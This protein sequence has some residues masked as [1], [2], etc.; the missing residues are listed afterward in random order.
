MRLQ[1]FA[2]IARYRNSGDPFFLLFAPQAVHTGNDYSVLQ[3]PQSFVDRFPGIRDH[4][5]RVFAGMLSALDDSV[6]EIFEELS[7][8]EAINNTIIVFTTDNGGATGGTEFR[9][10][11][12]VG[13]N[14]PLRGVKYTLW[15]GGIKGVAFVWSRLLNYS[16]YE[17]NN[18]MHIQ[19]WLPTLYTAAGGQSSQLRSTIDGI[20]FWDVLSNKKQ[21][22]LRTE[23]LHNID[24]IWGVYAL[25]YKDYKLIYGTVFNGVLDSWFK[26]P[27]LQ[28]EHSENEIVSE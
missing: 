18:L 1:F 25:R 9:V 22:E 4:R 23:I 15:E 2:I 8:S 13:S 3:A 6:G 28:S 11:N 21:T 7:K 27:E 19:D 24:D 20:D 16:R 17:F 12:S 14:W 5:R 26:P 10:D